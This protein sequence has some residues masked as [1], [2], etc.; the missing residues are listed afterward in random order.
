VKKIIVLAALET[1]YL[2]NTRKLSETYYTGVGKI[3]AARTTTEILMSTKPDLIVNVG[4]VGC[5]RQ[6]LL[7]QVF[8]IRS[9]IERD[10]NAEPLVPRGEVPFSVDKKKF[11]SDFGDLLCATGDSFVTREDSWLI[12]QSV[13]VVDMELFAIAKVCE[14]YGVPWRSIK[15]ASDLADDNAANDWELS[16]D[17][18]RA[19]IDTLLSEATAF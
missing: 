15:F 5:L 18:S 19:R 3:N 16:L 10:M 8:G 1:E 9:V 7:G 14:R 12:D 13:D 11:T 17:K 6:D 2:S 4:T